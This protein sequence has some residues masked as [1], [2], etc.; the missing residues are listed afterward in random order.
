MKRLLFSLIALAGL[1]VAAREM[2][3]QEIAANHRISASNHTA[4]PITADSLAPALTPAPA[5]Y[6]PFYINHYGRHGS[7]WLSNRES[8]SRPVEQLLRARDDNQLTA[9]GEQLLRV[10]QRVE[11]ASLL[12]TGD[13]SDV[14]AEQ[15]QGIARRMLRNFPG[16][17]AGDAT[18]DARSTVV[19]RCILS[20]QNETMTLR[21]A[22][23]R[24]RIT[25][26]ASYHDMHYMSYGYGP[27]TLAKELRN[28]AGRLSDSLY[29][30]R[31]D[32]ERFIATLIR[33]RDY[34]DRALNPRRLM[35]DVFQIAG[36]LQNH[37]QF[38]D[39]NLFYLFT[40]DEIFDLWQQRNIY[41]YNRWANAP[42]NGSQMP[43]I[44]RELLRNI[45]ATA[46]SAILNN[47]HG[48]S[49]RFGH[50]TII[51]PLACLMEIDSFNY[52][53]SDIDNLHLHWQNY[54]IIPMAA[55]MQMILYRPDSGN[56]DILV[57]V[58][59]NEHEATLPV[60]TDNAP[61]YRWSDLRDYYL[62]K[63]SRTVTFNV[64]E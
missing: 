27:D 19:L 35:R 2:P 44:T 64:P 32:P 9:Q 57:K 20:M 62:G 51:L 36:S 11:N 23:P 63:L 39:L 55:N 33:D 17:F 46:D 56:G 34:A 40:D 26:D 28:A 7:R 16:V 13:L 21:A 52:A 5:G 53:A 45:I 48:A 37:H 29:S 4:Y 25:T 38:D 10:L 18:V 61:Y 15:H 59:Y 60:K 24:L 6:T 8:Y 3:R 50:D 54:N 22:N 31:V 1:V 14:G 43:F 12:R 41:W 30:K 49:L 47:L 58:L 42:L